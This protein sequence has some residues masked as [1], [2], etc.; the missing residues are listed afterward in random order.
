VAVASAGKYHYINPISTGWFH[1]SKLQVTP[2]KKHNL[3]HN[4]KECTTHK[5][6]EHN[7]ER[8]SE[9]HSEIRLCET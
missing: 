4:E 3:L 1:I 7:E 5:G 2:E 8:K 9:M 6:S